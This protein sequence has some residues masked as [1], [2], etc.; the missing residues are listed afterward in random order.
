MNGTG[1]AVVQ[2]M[3]D[4]IVQ[5]FRPRQVILF[6]SRARGTATASSGVDL[7]VVCDEV[8]DKRRLAIEMGS[9]LSDMVV[10]KDIV[11]TTPD[12]IR[13]RGHLVGSILRPALRDGRVLYE[14]P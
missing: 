4:R 2:A 6:G 9:I 7:L 10:P 14:R 5:R 13:R 8:D 1:D 12:E 3:V 11:V